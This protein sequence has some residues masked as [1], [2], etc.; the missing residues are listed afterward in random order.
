MECVVSYAMKGNRSLSLPT[1]ETNQLESST[2]D[3]S[4]IRLRSVLAEM[5]LLIYLNVPQT[6]AVQ[7]VVESS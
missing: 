4:R 7:V 2:L 1:T 6:P 5:G 3:Y